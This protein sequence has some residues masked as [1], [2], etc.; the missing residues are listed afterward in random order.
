M[1]GCKLM[2]VCA[3]YNDSIGKMDDVPLFV[4]EMYCHLKPE[5]CV[6]FKESEYRDVSDIENRLT[7]WGIDCF[8][9]D[10]E[11]ASDTDP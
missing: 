1:F 10:T 3:F 6:R 7:P 8:T 9:E 11:D 5:M 2:E 4:K